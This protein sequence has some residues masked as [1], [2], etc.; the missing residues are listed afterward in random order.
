MTPALAETVTAAASADG[1]PRRSR[2]ARAARLAVFAAAS[3]ACTQLLRALDLA[4]VGEILG[5]VGPALGLAVIP[6]ACGIVLEGFGWRSLLTVLGFDVP[7]ATALRLA[8]GAEAA[9]LTLPGGGAAG[10]AVRAALFCGAARAPSSAGVTVLAV[11]KLSHL[12]SQG[13]YLLAAALFG[14]GLYATLGAAGRALETATA[15]VGAAFMAAAVVLGLALVHGS[16]ATRVER[17]LARV[18]RGWFAETVERRREGYAAVDA[19]LRGLLHRGGASHA[20]DVSLG[21]ALL[22]WFVE[23]GE[24]YLLLRLLGAPLGIGEAL[25]LEAL[26]SVARAAAF[27]VPGGLGVQ[28]FG[29]HALLHGA[30]EPVAAAFVLM[31]RARDVFWVTVGLAL[32]R[33]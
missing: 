6:F 19:G 30:G 24:S 32:S 2:A 29:Y 27:A 17:W 7:L 22:G 12:G 4:R 23:A 9:R 14:G 5:R 15:V 26:V 31:K 33:L 16:L 21:T 1:T 18:A 8:A 13:V 10:D 25:A 20:L 28:D 3:L 11:R